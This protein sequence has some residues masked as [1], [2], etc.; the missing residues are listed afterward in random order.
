MLFD[1]F[2]LAKWYEK[3]N[4]KIGER[5]TWSA[6]ESLEELA[7]PGWLVQIKERHERAMEAKE[8]LN[9]ITV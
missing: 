7:E 8:S 4:A 6:G 3:Y 2:E 9:L 5:H 1:L